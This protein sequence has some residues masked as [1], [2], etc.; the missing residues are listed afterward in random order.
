MRKFRKFETLHLGCIECDKYWH[1]LVASRCI[2]I[3]RW[4]KWWQD[5]LSAKQVL[6]EGKK[7]TVYKGLLGPRHVLG[8]IT[9]L[10]EL[11]TDA[12]APRPQNAI[13][14][15]CNGMRLLQWNAV[16]PLTLLP[17][18][19]YKAPLTLISYGC[20][21]AMQGNGCSGCHGAPHSYLLS[22]YI[23]I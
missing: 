5:A 23:Y 9:C 18:Y 11:P 1:R 22:P 21:G 15:Y 20:S 14:G 16:V 2:R 4:D 17:V 8:R 10:G 3:I 6:L 13:W 12:Q 19:L 7:A